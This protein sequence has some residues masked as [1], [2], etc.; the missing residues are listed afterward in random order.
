LKN[1]IRNIDTDLGTRSIEGCKNK[2]QPQTTAMY[3]VRY[4]EK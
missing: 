2:E 1:R 3:V 4:K